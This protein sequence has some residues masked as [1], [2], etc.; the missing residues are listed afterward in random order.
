MPDSSP[1]V[2][3]VLLS[4]NRL[5]Q[6]SY[7]NL[8]IT[9]VDNPSPQSAEVVRVVGE[10][11]GVKLI[12]NP[13]NLGYTGGMNRGLEEAT[14][15]YVLLTEDDIVAES[16]CIARLVEY[17]EEHSSAALVAPVI[18]NK[19]ERTIRCAGG[20]FTL[21]G[22]Y[23]R[24]IHGAGERDTGQFPQP[25]DVGY[26]DGAAMFARKSFWRQFK[27]FR[28]EY[29]MYVDAVEL[30]ARVGKSG[31]RMTIVPQ[32]K[33]YHF[34]PPETA[35]PPEIEFHKVKNFFSLYLLHAP[36]RHLPEF[37]CRYAILNTAR[38]LF[39]RTGQPRGA[40]LKALLWAAGKTPSLL[41][42]RYRQRSAAN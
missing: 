27:G 31:Q 12:T 3:V 33:V 10:H 5:V 16:N 11:Q 20:D 36:A 29:F 42:E 21:G 6:Q 14:G 37:V 39:G 9:V 35:T 23:R 38:S 40:H 34:E 25:F 28:A 18:Y 22:V 13:T 17:M 7:A 2:S 19:R 41:R 26:I 24:K 15:A 32:A 1:L 8:E 30:C 4:Y